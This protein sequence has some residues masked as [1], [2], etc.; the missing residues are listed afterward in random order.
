[1]S[2]KLPIVIDSFDITCKPALATN[3][4]IYPSNT[5]SG[6]AYLFQHL[7]LGSTSLGLLELGTILE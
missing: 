7:S 5:R 6:H 3:F 2:E 1:M 4:S